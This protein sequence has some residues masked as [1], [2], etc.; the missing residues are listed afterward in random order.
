MSVELE[1]TFIM[2]HLE[3]LRTFCT[4]VEMQSFTHAAN[5]LGV[6]T[7][8]VSRAIT[9]LETRL[10]VRLF[11]RTTRHLALTEAGDEFHAGC[12]R[13]VA[14]LDLLEAG[15]GQRAREPAGVLRLVAHTTAA[16]LELPPLI[17]GFRARYPAVQLELTLAE[18]PVDLIKEAFDLGIVL[19]FMLTSELTIT[20]ALCRLPLAVVGSPSYLQGRQLPQRPNDLAAFRFVT[21]LASI[22]EPQ[23]RFQRGGEQFAVPLEHDV[24]TNNAALNKELVVS[25]AGLG[26]LPLTMVGKELDDGRLVQLLPDFEVVSAQAELR[27]AYRDRSLMTA[28]VRAFIDYVT[29]YFDAR[30]AQVSHAQQRKTVA[31][32]SDRPS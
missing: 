16:V 31:A 24:S 8:I 15:T 32:G 5:K 2:D 9:G 6:S 3:T 17:A 21:I 18:R 19:P 11:Q 1:Q 20:R 13:V 26:A 7:S 10:G 4:V 30:A 28:K 22:S 14:E 25:G 12:S 29:S 23:L 27:L